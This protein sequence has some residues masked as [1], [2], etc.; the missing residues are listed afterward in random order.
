MLLE[1]PEGLVAIKWPQNLEDFDLGEFIRDLSSRRQR[2]DDDNNVFL[3][4]STKHVEELSKHLLEAE[5]GTGEVE[6]G[7]RM[8]ARRL[9]AFAERSREVSSANDSASAERGA[10]ASRRKLMSAT[11]VILRFPPNYHSALTAVDASAQSLPPDLA[12]ALRYIRVQ[13]VALSTSPLNQLK[14]AVDRSSRNSTLRSRAAVAIVEFCLGNDTE[15][16]A[17]R[18]SQVGERTGLFNRAAEAAIA[19]LRAVVISTRPRRIGDTRDDQGSESDTSSLS[20][21]SSVA[22]DDADGAPLVAAVVGESPAVAAAT[23]A[24]AAGNLAAAF[25]SAFGTVLA[26]AAPA[27]R[28]ICVGDE[29]VAGVLARGFGVLT[30]KAFER[31]AERLGAVAAAYVAAAGAGAWASLAKQAVIVAASGASSKGFGVKRSKRGA[32]PAGAVA[33]HTPVSHA[34]DDDAASAAS[35]VSSMDDANTSV[36]FSVALPPAVHSSGVAAGTAGGV[37]A[38]AAA[39]IIGVMHVVVDTV[40]I[41][42]HMLLHLVTSSPWP[43]RCAPCGALTALGGSVVAR[44]DG[45]SAAS[46]VL[47]EGGLSLLGAA[48]GGGGDS[49]ALASVLVAL[50]EIATLGPDADKDPASADPRLRAIVGA[51]HAHRGHSQDAAVVA[52]LRSA[53]MAVSADGSDVMAL[54]GSRAVGPVGDAV[55]AAVA[56]SDDSEA[57]GV[58]VRQPTPVVVAKVVKALLGASIPARDAV[59]GGDGDGGVSSDGSDE[60]VGAPQLPSRRARRARG[61]RTFVAIVSDLIVWASAAAV[62][63]ARARAKRGS[64]LLLV[65][66]MAALDAPPFATV[67]SHDPLSVGPRVARAFLRRLALHIDVAVEG[68]C[69]RLVDMSPYA[70]GSDAKHAPA[71]RAAAVAA[72]LASECLLTAATSRSATV[73][74]PPLV[75]TVA[76]GWCVGALGASASVALANRQ[77]APREAAHPHAGTLVRARSSSVTPSPA[78]RRSMIELPLPRMTDTASFRPLPSALLTSALSSHAQRVSAPSSISERPSDGVGLRP[79]PADVTYYSGPDAVLARIVAAAIAAVDAAAPAVDADSVLAQVAQGSSA[80]A[81]RSLFRS[82]PKGADPS[83]RDSAQYTAAFRFRSLSL[84]VHT[85]CQTIDAIIVRPLLPEARPVDPLYLPAGV[86]ALLPSTASA[87]RGAAASITRAA[88]AYADILIGR[89][90][91]PLV[92]AVG[93]AGA[94][95][96]PTRVPLSAHVRRD[97]VVSAVRAL[98]RGALQRLVKRLVKHSTKHVRV[99]GGLTRELVVN[100]WSA[101]HRRFREVMVASDALDAVGEGRRSI[102][103]D[104]VVRAFNSELTKAAAAVGIAYP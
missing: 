104:R 98:A 65:P 27:L 58:A 47:S 101:V 43:A 60:D 56:W 83:A 9:A 7:I 25:L 74:L 85:I 8:A 66:V 49:G 73:H 75:T 61:Q 31:L 12:A 6:V 57:D 72:T 67:T 84:V 41:A 52:P 22:P 63:A 70:R 28:E 59:A 94:T 35:G 51:P 71:H 3:L 34:A 20:S 55:A 93:P 78:R 100:L 19:S 99:P 10:V 33:L 96:D 11:A 64:P 95:A 91:G 90:M 21:I 13:S 44:D 29:T 39:A 80:T 36:A 77:K 68:A 103:V 18:K 97:A 48:M 17:R 86:R 38:A 40:C 87:L 14:A 42:R 82:H 89:D 30:G 53:V 102:D 26:P 88:E 23:A 24:A 81:A 1:A 32:D 50:A 4:H 76:G 62:P 69:A 92:I 15:R 54:L 79:P 45:A 16:D 2:V 46:P 5:S 37:H